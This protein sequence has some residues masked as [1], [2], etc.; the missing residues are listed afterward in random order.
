MRQNVLPILEA[1]GVDLVLTGHSH[2][3]ERSFLIDGHYGTSGHLGTGDHALDAGDGRTTAGGDGAYIKPAGGPTPHE[4]AVYVVAG[5]SA[6]ITAGLSTIP[7]C[8]RRSAACS[9][10][11][12]SRST[13][14]AWT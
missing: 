14:T 12:C 4:G 2:S 10:R 3:Y 1:G 7:R 8:S 5:S 13:A 6:K 9:V 11:W